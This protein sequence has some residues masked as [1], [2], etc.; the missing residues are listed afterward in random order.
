MNQRMTIPGRSQ[1][2]VA[3]GVDQLESCQ[4]LSLALLPLHSS[5][6]AHHHG[7]RTHRPAVVERVRQVIMERR[8]LWPPPQ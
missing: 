3:L 1:C 6:L 2:R 7:M 5:I 8:T 4:L